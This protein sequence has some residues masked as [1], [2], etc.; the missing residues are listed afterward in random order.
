MR[1]MSGNRMFAASAALTYVTVGALMLVW[2]LVW[3][4]YLTESEAPRR[5]YYYLCYGFM[6]TG[7]ILLLIGFAVGRIGRAAREAELPPKEVTPTVAQ[8]EQTAAT[9]APTMTPA[10]PAQPAVGAPPPQA[11]PPAIPVKQPVTQR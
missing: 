5:V 11:A 9:R 6:G 7:I 8:I 2:S 3:Y 10:A 1:L 4:W